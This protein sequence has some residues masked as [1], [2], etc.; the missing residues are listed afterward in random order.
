V[1]KNII[2]IDGKSCPIRKSGFATKGEAQSA[3]REIE[4]KL[5]NGGVSPKDNITLHQHFKEWIQLYKK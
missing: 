4:S 3:A 5:A 2:E 1:F